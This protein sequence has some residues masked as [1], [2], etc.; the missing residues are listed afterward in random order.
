MTADPVAALAPDRDVVAGQAREAVARFA[1]LV[2]RIGPGDPPAVGDWSVRDVAVHVAW[3]MD[4]YTDFLGGTPS[5]A[6]AVEQTATFSAAAIAEATDRTPEGLARAVDEAGERYFAAAARAE[7]PVTWHAGLSLSVP[8]LLGLTLGEA[9]VHGHDVA[10]ALGE[11]WE[12]P[13]AW[14]RTVFRA[15]LPALPLYVDAAATAG[16]HARID[17]R[18]RGD[19]GAR[20]VFDV[21]D[22]TLTVRPAPVADPVDCHLWADPAA[23]LLVF[24]GRTTPMRP[25]LRGRI[26]A[27]GRRPWLGFA[28]PGYLRRP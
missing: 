9:L 15:A 14:A 17:V 4:R 22:G 2:R 20:V 7:G 8:A 1:A 18:L 10:V 26:L 12:L 5:P 23:F 16:V 19:P 25:A 11:P 24:Y 27:W 28:L 6:T 21:A 3:A 13:R